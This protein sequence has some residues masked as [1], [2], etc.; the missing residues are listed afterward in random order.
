MAKGLLKQFEDRYTLRFH[1]RDGT[2]INYHD[3]RLGFIRNIERRIFKGK[4]S[5]G[6]GHVV[7]PI[8]QITYTELFPYEQ[9]NE[10]QL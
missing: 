7:I 10:D 8:Q 2:E 4:G 5:L 1:L 3:L 9:W 6:V